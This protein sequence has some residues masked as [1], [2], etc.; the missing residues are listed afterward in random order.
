[1]TSSQSPHYSSEFGFLLT[2]VAGYESLSALHLEIDAI[3][4]NKLCGCATHN[5]H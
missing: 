5:Q 2:Q 1:M 3:A 4:N